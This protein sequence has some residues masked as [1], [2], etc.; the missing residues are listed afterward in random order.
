MEKKYMTFKAEI[1]AADSDG[2]IGKITG[3]ASAYGVK[4]SYGDIVVKG[5][6]SR[7]L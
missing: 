6:F 3:Y 5:A 1:K 2:K 7:S 4:D